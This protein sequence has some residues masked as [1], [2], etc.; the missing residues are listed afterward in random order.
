MVDAAAAV[1]VVVAVRNVSY[2]IAKL[3]L[4]GKDL[5]ICVGRKW[6]S[7]GQG[8]VDW[9]SLASGMMGEHGL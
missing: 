3:W 8:V 6:L 5:M 4:N 7:R 9:L 2:T 1:V